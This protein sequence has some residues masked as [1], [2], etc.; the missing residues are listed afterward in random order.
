MVSLYGQWSFI[1]GLCRFLQ[2]H[3]RAKVTVGKKCPLEMVAMEYLRVHFATDK[4]DIAASMRPRRD[5]V[6]P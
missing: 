4:L 6:R 2:L 3:C 5:Q 1:G